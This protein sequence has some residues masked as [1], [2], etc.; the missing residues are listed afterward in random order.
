M[1][2]QIMVKKWGKGEKP[3]INPLKGRKVVNMLGP[4]FSSDFIDGLLATH[5]FKTQTHGLSLTIY[6]CVNLNNT[7]A[8][9]S[10]NRG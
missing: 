9:E 2:L 10:G 6:S 3:M 7:S 1:A 5:H 4:P 8:L